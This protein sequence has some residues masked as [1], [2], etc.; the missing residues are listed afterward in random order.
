MNGDWIARLPAFPDVCASVPSPATVRAGGTDWAAMMEIMALQR[1]VINRLDLFAAP[2][3]TLNPNLVALRLLDEQFL[4]RR[5]SPG[6]F[7]RASGRGFDHRKGL[8]ELKSDEAA[9]M[10][11]V[12]ADWA[13]LMDQSSREHRR[14]EARAPADEAP[15]DAPAGSAATRAPSDPSP[16]PAPEGV[17]AEDSLQPHAGGDD[18]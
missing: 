13:A 15:C 16:P 7:A 2:P 17:G 8:L 3:L 6:F 12:S 14:V 4:P 1:A 10:S 9:A 5:G 11:R 18:A